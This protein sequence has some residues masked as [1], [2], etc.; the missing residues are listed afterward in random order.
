V[1]VVAVL[2]DMALPVVRGYIIVA[3]VAVVALLVFDIH[4]Q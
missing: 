2:L 4:S 3:V 1:A